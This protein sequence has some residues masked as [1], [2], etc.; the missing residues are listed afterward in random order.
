MTTSPA[1]I[2]LDRTCFACPEQY[3]ARD[4][5]GTK[6]AYLRLRHGYFTVEMPGP[7][8]REV[9][10]ARP[11]G[12]G[13]FGDDERDHYLNAA[14][15]VIAGCL[16]AASD[17]ASVLPEVRRFLLDMAEIACPDC[18]STS[19]PDDMGEAIDWAIA[20]RCGEA[21]D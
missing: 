17:P 11:A 21:T 3:D 5:H 6:V 20:H 8:G 16:R 14:R 10:S 9:Y 12:D 4:E 19:Y 13:I 2:T 1:Q 7:G 15:I 18:G